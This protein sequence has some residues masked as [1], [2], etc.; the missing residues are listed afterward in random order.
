MSVTESASGRLESIDICLECSFDIVSIAITI[1]IWLSRG[2][3]PGP[4]PVPNAHDQEELEEMMAN[5]RDRIPA[6]YRDV[7]GLFERYA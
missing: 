5:D 3:R 4:T 6:I 7:V 2:A 1:N